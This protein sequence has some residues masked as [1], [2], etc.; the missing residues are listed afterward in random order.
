MSARPHGRLIIGSAYP[1][2]WERIDLVACVP[3]P[4]ML[5]AQDLEGE[6]LVGA[7]REHAAKVDGHVDRLAQLIEEGW[8]ISSHG[9][10]IARRHTESTEHARELAN[11]QRVLGHRFP[12]ELCV[13]AGESPCLTVAG[14]LLAGC[15]THPEIYPPRTMPALVHSEPSGAQRIAHDVRQLRAAIAGGLAEIAE[16]LDGRKTDLHDLLATDLPAA[17]RAL[18]H[19]V[20]SDGPI[21]SE[22][23]IDLGSGPLL[24]DIERGCV[25][26]TPVTAA[27]WSGVSEHLKVHS[28]AH[29]LVMFEGVGERLELRGRKIAAD[30][31]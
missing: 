20:Q 10:L 28:N 25:S 13:G 14:G 17:T 1:V 18:A 22:V 31:L 30:L 4:S 16:W 5:P 12:F 23:G 2:S 8:T 24:G 29:G 6:D 15:P 9:A 19:E 3:M 27:V 21:P 11:R 7:W 26:I